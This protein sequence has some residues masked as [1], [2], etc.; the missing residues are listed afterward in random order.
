MERVNPFSALIKDGR[1][2]IK[3]RF[4]QGDAAEFDLFVR[5]DDLKRAHIHDRAG[6]DRERNT[7]VLLGQG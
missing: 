7:D 2:I 4:E 1:F 6:Q 3:T 5:P